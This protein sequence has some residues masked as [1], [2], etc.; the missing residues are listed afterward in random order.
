DARRGGPSGAIGCPRGP[1]PGGRARGTER[2]LT[3]AT[4]D[5]VAGEPFRVTA[6]VRSA[7]P[8][9]ADASVSLSLP[10]GWATIGNGRLGPVS[11]PAESTATFTVTPPAGVPPGRFRIGATLALGDASGRTTAVVRLVPAVQGRVERLPQV[12]QF[13]KWARDVGVP[14][15]GSTVKPVLSLGVGETRTSRVAVDNRSAR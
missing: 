14:Q 11:G 4:F 6:H 8:A 9:M 10:D 1:A 2:S 3:S 7:G 5:A 13:E 12:A 15:L